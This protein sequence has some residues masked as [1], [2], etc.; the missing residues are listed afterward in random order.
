MTKLYLKSALKNKKM[1]FG[2][3]I[4]ILALP[5]VF[6]YGYGLM[7][8]SLF[9]ASTPQ[10]PFETPLRNAVITVLTPPNVLSPIAK[11]QLSVFTGMTFFL[12]SFFAAKFVK[13]RRSQFTNRLVAMGYTKKQ[14]F[15]GEG[16]SYFLVS[17]LMIGAFNVLFSI[18]HKVSLASDA[19]S[20]ILFG[21]LILSQGLFSSAYALFALGIFKTEKSF[22]L[23]H[24][25]PAFIISFIGGAFFP[26]EQIS[27]GGFYEWMPT[28]Q[29]NKIYEDWYVFNSFEMGNLWIAFGILGLAS[30]ILLGIGYRTFKLE[31]VGTC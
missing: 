27:N 14:V 12:V 31:E 5:L 4:I 24:F 29:L 28:Y 11:M 19:K 16:I 22:A 23:F 2:F 7:Y 9:K 15:L 25:L 1:Q 20:Y 21:V 3:I 13:N 17:T 10:V 30:F 18:I 26:V 8:E 6:G